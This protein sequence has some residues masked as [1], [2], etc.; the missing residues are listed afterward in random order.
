M[1]NSS[2]SLQTF[3]KI[4]LIY[5]SKHLHSKYIAE[6]LEATEKEFWKVKTEGTAQWNY[7]WNLIE[8]CPDS[9]ESI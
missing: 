4:T 9:A 6:N 8:N 5:V 3:V 1:L 7:Y 2:A